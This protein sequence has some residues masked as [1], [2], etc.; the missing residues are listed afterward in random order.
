MKLSSPIHDSQ[1]IPGLVSII[2]PTR[3]SGSTLSD[4]LRSIHAQ[5]YPGIEV[6]VVDNYSSDD[7]RQIA[8]AY[9]AKVLLCGGERSRQVNAGVEISQGEFVY[10]TDGD[11]VLQENV[12]AECVVGCK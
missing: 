4:C 8:L 2:I 6:I 9:H 3:N 11:F 10:R 7:T 1:L 5:S 12:V